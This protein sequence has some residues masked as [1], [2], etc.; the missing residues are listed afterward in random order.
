MTLN[1]PGLMRAMNDCL[2]SIHT[3]DAT[4]LP[5]FPMLRVAVLQFQE[6]LC[7]IL[8]VAKEMQVKA[9]WVAWRRKLQKY[10]TQALHQLVQNGSA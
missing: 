5:Q 6:D 3:K 10:N 9:K 2:C 7:C 8:L 1:C 4:P